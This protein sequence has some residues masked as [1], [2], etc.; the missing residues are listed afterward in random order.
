MNKIGM[1]YKENG[2]RIEYTVKGTGPAV[3]VL[4]G[5]HS[6]C[7]EQLG[8]EELLNAGY[9][10]I[11]PSRSGYG[12]T[13]TACGASLETAAANWIQVLDECSIQAAAVI[14]MSA[15]GP[16]GIAL[17]ALYP[18]RVKCLVLQSAV[19]KK[20]LTPADREYTAAQLLFNRYTEK[21]TWRMLSA[22]SRMSPGLVYRIMSSSFSTLPYEEVASAT[23]PEDIP[24][25]TQMIRRQRSKTGFLNDI[26]LTGQCTPGLLQKIT[27]PVLVQ[28]SQND[29]SVDIAHMYHVGNHVSQAELQPLNTWGHLIWLG[30]HSDQMKEKLKQFLKTYS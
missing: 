3:L 21:G 1:I 14:A 2:S 8:Y 5:G 23:L 24:A 26:A 28:H 18:E 15:G 17:A 30:K 6:N 19:T 7:R 9:S 11:T 22:A 20:W 29:A 27:C 4:H 16:E 10:I 12:E 25:F 13:T